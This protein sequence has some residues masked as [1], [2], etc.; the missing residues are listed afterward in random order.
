MVL[1]KDLHRV[2]TWKGEVHEVEFYIGNTLYEGLVFEEGNDYYILNNIHIIKP[3]KHY[4]E[5]K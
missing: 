1:K 3:N 5:Q 2:S 4:S